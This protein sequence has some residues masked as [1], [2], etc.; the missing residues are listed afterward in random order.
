MLEFGFRDDPAYLAL[1][2]VT[3]TAFT[4][5]A[6]PPCIVS[7]PF[8]QTVPPGAGATFSVAA[9]GST[10]LSYSW[11]CNGSPIAGATQSSYTVP[12]AQMNAGCQFS[13]LVTNTY[14]AIISSTA[15]LSVAGPLHS[16][17]GPDGGTP[18]AALVQG[19]D[20]SFYGTTEYGGAYGYGTVFK[21][22]TNGTSTLLS[23]NYSNG[24]FPEAGLV[25]GAD[26][27]FY[28]TTSSGGI[29]GAGTVFKI[30]ASGTLTTLA[31]FNSSTNG[32][33]PCAPLAQGVDGSFYGTTLSGGTNGGYGTI[34]RITA[35]GILTALVS[36]NSTNGASPRAGLVQGND[37][38]FYGTTYSGGT[39]GGYGTVFKMTTNGALTSLVSF[40]SA[41]GAYPRAGLV[42]GNDGSFYGTTGSGGLNYGGTLFRI[43]TDGTLTTLVSFNYFNYTHGAYPYAGLVQ[44]ADGNLYGTTASGGGFNAGTIFRLASDGTLAALFSFA[45]TNGAAPQAALVPGSDGNFY[46]TTAYGGVGYNGYSSSGDGTVFC[47]LLAP[48]VAP[49]AIISQPVSQTIPAGGT[50]TFSAPAASSAPLNYFWRRNGVPVTGA[51]E[52]SYTTNNLQ[53]TDSGSQ[54]SCLVSNAL[55]SV[56]SSNAALNV[57]PVNASGPVFTFSGFDGGCLYAGLVQGADGYFYGTT[58]YGGTYGYG[59]VFRITTDGALTTLASFNSTNGASPQAALVQAADGNFYG[60]TYSGGANGLG[61]V[62]RITTKGALAT[63]ASFDYSVNGGYPVAP[64]MQ[65]TDGNLYGTTPSGGTCGHGTVFSITT[66]G[67]LTTLASFNSTNGA[68]PYAGLVQGSDGN[69]YGTT[70]SGG[71][72]GYGTVFSITTNGT[73]TT[74]VSFD[75]YT[76]GGNPYGALALGADGNFYGT[77]FAGAPTAVMAMERYLRSQPIARSPPWLHSIT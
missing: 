59:T 3:V 56:L 11:L 47:L 19:A 62:F 38:I 18:Y 24:S 54:F 48:T 52:S 10:P 66:S 20:G 74:L 7:Q 60:T 12:S 67:A 77:T 43:T 37:G 33:Y 25:Q 68:N 31:S 72:G 8:S 39:N 14:G 9:L 71:A 27:N 28:G 22:T 53:L 41:D 61:T 58:E 42:Q 64:L 30:A 49:P 29:F 32:G 40:N 6:S 21:M 75:R 57:L 36:F 46:G 35:N 23:F 63:L 45:G 13:C 55:A 16:F 26:G 17:I 1:D 34:F 44:G 69:F 73:L 65:G 15:L 2:D 50:V 5:V 70:E 76:N 51:T 4:N